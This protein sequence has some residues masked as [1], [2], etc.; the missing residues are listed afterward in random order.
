ML[1]ISGRRFCAYPFGFFTNRL[2][3]LGASA[4]AVWARAGATSPLRAFVNKPGLFL[5][6]TDL[7]GRMSD[8]GFQRWKIGRTRREAG[9]TGLEFYTQIKTVYRGC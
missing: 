2:L 3:W 6:T 8:V 1:K 5:N 4:R 9:R 7:Q